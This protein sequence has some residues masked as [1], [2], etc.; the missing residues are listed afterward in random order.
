MFQKSLKNNLGEDDLLLIEEPTSDEI[1][2]EFI[3]PHGIT[4]VPQLT[5]VSESYLEHSL[6]YN[7]KFYRYSICITDE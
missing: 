6:R 5:D 7:L 2:G 1:F 3:L 4:I